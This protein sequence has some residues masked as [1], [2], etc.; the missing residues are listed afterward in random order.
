MAAGGAGCSRPWA[1]P[2][3]S[4]RTCWRPC[5]DSAGIM[6]A[7]SVVF[8]A[9]RWAGV[10]YLVFMGFSMIREAGTLPLEDQD[11]PV[12]SAGSIVWRGVLL[13]VLNPKL[14]LFFFAF[15]PQ[16]LDASP[17]LLDTRLIQLGGVFML[18]TLVVFAVY[19]LASAAVRDLRT[20]RPRRPRVDR[21]CVR[22]CPDRIRSQTSP[23]R[24]G[25]PQPSGRLSIMNQVRSNLYEGS[26]QNRPPARCAS[27]LPVARMDDKAGHE[28]ERMNDE[29]LVQIE[30]EV[31]G[32]DGVFK[33]GTR[34]V[35][36]G[37]ASP[38]TG[39]ETPRRRTPDRARP[40]RRPR[41]LPVPQRRKGRV[42]PLRAGDR[43]SRLSQQPDDGKLPIQSAEDVAGAL[44]LFRMNYD[45]VRERAN[46][47]PQP[48][49]DA[50][51]VGIRQRASCCATVARSTR[52]EKIPS[53]IP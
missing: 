49:D 17:G 24:I 39:T 26:G 10:A 45:P 46:A 38:A 6:Q 36:V 53:W 35:L 44:E 5:S 30:R 51:H 16:F 50:W 8:E 21:A 19:A 27:L 2:L 52:E 13:N 37:S 41:R 29:P 34:T 11:A 47:K 18:M 15:L 33:R 48:G 12:N 25:D 22:G 43:S 14:T 9:V 31:L 4:S 3:A 42:D 28:R 20:R 1:A 32:W 23:A 7:G 40:R